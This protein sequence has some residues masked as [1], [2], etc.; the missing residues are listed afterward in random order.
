MERDLKERVEEYIKANSVKL[1]QKEPAAPKQPKAPKKK[2]EKKE[3]P[4]VEKKEDVPAEVPTEA[5]SSE[6][7]VCILIYILYLGT[8][9]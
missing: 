2:T 6:K 1:V 4:K 5:P 7:K 8:R 9:Y 3:E